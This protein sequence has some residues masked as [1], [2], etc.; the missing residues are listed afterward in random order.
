MSVFTLASP[1]AREEVVSIL[2]GSTISAVTMERDAS[3]SDKLHV[4]LLLEDGV[5]LKFITGSTR[6]FFVEAD[7]N[8]PQFVGGAGDTPPPADNLFRLRAV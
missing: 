7:V 2:T 1:E 4:E 3:G 6:S 8:L 5:R